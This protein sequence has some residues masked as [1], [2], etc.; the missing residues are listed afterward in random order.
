[1]IFVEKRMN[2]AIAY[3]LLLMAVAIHGFHAAFGQEPVSTEYQYDAA[4]NR[5]NATNQPVL[6]RPVAISFY[7]DYGI[8]G[9]RFN[10]YGSHLPVVD[11]SQY[12][13]T[14]NGA[15]APVLHVAPSV[16][17]V[18]IP[19]GATTGPLI[20]TLPDTTPFDLGEYHI[21]DDIDKD[22]DRMPDFVEPFLQL[23]PTLA[24]TNND[25]VL[26]GDEDF[27]RDNLSNY[28]EFVMGTNPKNPDTD[29]DG[30][31][32]GNEDR[33]LDY[34]SDGEEIRRGTNPF[35][36][37]TDGDLFADVDEIAL[38]SDP[39][40]PA[41]QPDRLVYSA[42]VSYVNAILGEDSNERYVASQPVAYLNAQLRQL[43]PQQFASSPMVSFLN[44]QLREIDPQRFAVSQPVSYLNG[45][46][47]ESDRT[48]FVMSPIV[49]YENQ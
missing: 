25:G 20:V 7:P 32:D 6:D 12:A 3:R 43:D 4:G 34:V 40:D 47:N 23:D 36:P 42:P 45:I 41:R 16:I 39:I 17:T 1:M 2:T 14:I 33:D 28:G 9:G 13:V 38:G 27:D 48:A 10:I 44:A 11:S 15:A 46:L 19:A 24:D 31:L 22:Q 30:I 26:D 21:L 5:V 29:R 18:E 49:S 37:D 35:L 8:P